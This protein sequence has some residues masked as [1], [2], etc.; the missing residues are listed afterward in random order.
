MKS[1]L[2]KHILNRSRSE[3][4][5]FLI[6][7]DI[8]LIPLIL[9]ISFY[10]TEK[11]T[12]LQNSYNWLVFPLSILVAIPIYMK[13]GL[14]RAILKY[15]RSHA[16]GSILI[17]TLIAAVVWVGALV[18]LNFQHIPSS[19]VLLYWLGTFM[20][21]TVTRL[22]AQ[23]WLYGEIS[24]N[25]SAKKVLI[26]GA[27]SA[28]SQLAMVLKPDPS[29]SLI[30]FIDDDKSLEGWNVLGLK[31]FSPLQL[32]ASI[33]KYCVDEVILALPSA[34][35][36]NRQLI[37]EQLEKLPVHVRS[38]PAFADLVS[39]KL[40]T[41]DIN[42]IDI[43]DLLGRNI[44]EPDSS[45]LPIN[46]TNKVIMVTGAGGSIGSELCRQIISLA[47][48][49]LILLEQSEFALYKIEQ[50]LDAL[51]KKSENHIEL[52]RVLGS[53]T[54]EVLLKRLF[55]NKTIQTIYHAAAYKHVPL[56]EENPVAGLANNVFGTQ[57]LAETAMNANAESF[58]LI[59]TDKA[60]RPTNVMG[61]SKRIAELILQALA[62]KPESKT[63]FTMVRFGNVLGSSGS[64][65]P[66]FRQQ[67]K[68]GG[69][70][71]V[72]HKDITRFF[73]SIPEAVQLVIQ[74]GAMAKGGDVFVLDM[75]ESV[76][77]ADLAEKMIKLSGLSV[78]NDKN[79]DGDI[80]IQ[81]NG[82]R[83]GEKLYEELLI[84][85]NV[86][87]TKHQ[88]IMR[89][90]EEFMTWS[91]LEQKLDKLEKIMQ[92]DNILEIKSQLTNIVDGYKPWLEK[93]IMSDNKNVIPITK[94]Y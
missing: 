28:G 51:I 27:G 71:T 37:L 82:L 52:N 16:I 11:Q 31:V 1:N 65:V 67:I 93:P 55:Q 44:V 53:V 79:P 24:K 5:L 48:K 56:V 84:G 91:T 41:A 36:S 92:V 47:P 64:V 70:I 38:I 76:K 58:I 57:L 61:C 88:R 50:E 29:Y 90:N 9:F 23:Q 10:S 54:N 85:E 30:G 73:M 63:V 3:K 33:E 25:A 17:A 75:G 72:T 21:I 2:K 18:L 7:L 69:P 20:V 80:A 81:F 4:R 39:G 78:K 15:F 94:S 42:D 32:P 66:K 89:A 40:Q 49:K 22:S 83:P 60:V 14:Y 68:E 43:D 74:A 26:Y 19:V 59:S 6:A 35:R 45:L 77:I 62:E 12:F 8:F 13:M 46:I 87:G 34:N 86:S